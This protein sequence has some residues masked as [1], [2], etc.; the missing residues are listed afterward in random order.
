MSE[1]SRKI[2]WTWVVAFLYLGLNCQPNGVFNI[3]RTSTDYF[4]AAFDLLQW[5][6]CFKC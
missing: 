4:N 1:L 2:G 6:M 3:G 5:E